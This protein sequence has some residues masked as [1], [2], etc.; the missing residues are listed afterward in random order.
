MA[1]VNM[2]VVNGLKN[3]LLNICGKQENSIRDAC[4]TQPGDIALDTWSMRYRIGKTVQS[5]RDF[6]ESII[7][8]RRCSYGAGDVTLKTEKMYV[9]TEYQKDNSMAR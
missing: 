6:Q 3:K 7:W 9:K 8:C 4:I 1:V 5:L 2:A